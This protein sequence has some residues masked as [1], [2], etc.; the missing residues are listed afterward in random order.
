MQTLT[1]M[2]M[3]DAFVAKIV[4]I[5]PTFE[6]NRA[7]GWSFT[8]S[9]HRSLGGRS[10]LPPSCRSFDLAFGL[11]QPSY[12]WHGGTG[13]AYKVGLAVC[14]SYSGVPSDYLAHMISQDGVDLRH[15]LNMLRDPTLPGLVNIEPAGVAN[16]RVDDESNA[17]LEHLFAVSYHQAAMA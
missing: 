12:T 3:A 9:H 7:S 16:V 14:V 17:Y 15:A 2:A 8:P 1:T 11:A 13:T 5:V 4:S 6:P 10:E